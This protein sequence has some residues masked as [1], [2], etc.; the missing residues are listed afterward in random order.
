[1]HKLLLEKKKI[2]D[3]FGFGL[4]MGFVGNKHKTVSLN[5]SFFF[6]KKKKS[7]IVGTQL[8]EKMLSQMP[9]DCSLT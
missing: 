5:L 2:T 9:A 6:F 3:S 8:S 4:F 7:L 1:M